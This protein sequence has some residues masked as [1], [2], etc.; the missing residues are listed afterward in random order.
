MTV[1]VFL[2]GCGTGQ[3]IS[4]QSTIPGL[5]PVAMFYIRSLNNDEI[6][7]LEKDDD[8]HQRGNSA[9]IQ[10]CQPYSKS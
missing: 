7:A 9:F 2:K 1:C 10:V 6:T 5:W 4:A 8:T 3:D